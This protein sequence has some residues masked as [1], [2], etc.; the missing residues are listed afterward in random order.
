M[1]PI[2]L[3]TR[4][5]LVAFSLLAALIALPLSVIAA[6]PSWWTTRGVTNGNEANDYSAVNQGQVKNIATKAV[7]ELESSLAQFGGAGESLL[8]LQSNLSGTSTATNDYATANL[9]QLKHIAVPILGR[10]LEIGYREHPLESGTFPWVGSTANDYAMANIGQV[11]NLFSFDLTLCSD[12]SGLPDW[13]RHLYSIPA[14]TNGSSPAPGY[15]GLSYLEAYNQGLNPNDCFNGR[16]PVLSIV[17]GNGQADY[18]GACLQTPLVVSILDANGAPFVGI[19]ITFAV[20]QGGGTLQKLGVAAGTNVTLD[21][22]A[23]GQAKIFFQLP[24][25][26]ETTCTITAVAG[27]GAHSV[28]AAFTET[29]VAAPT[30]AAPKS[31]VTDVESHLNEDGSIDMTWTNT[32]DPDDPEPITIWSRDVKGNWKIVVSGLPAGTTSYHIPPE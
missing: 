15:N 14:G 32:N 7:D 3:L 22:D 30:T 2:F 23:S 4:R 9:G 20:T 27:A 25:N 21:T 16:T 28:Q 31:N 8:Q 24:S 6:Q 17:S 18:P 13:W 26:P 12:G 19:P 11:K 10:L 5:P 1:K 29:V